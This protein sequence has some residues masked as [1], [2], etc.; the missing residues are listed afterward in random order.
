MTGMDLGELGEFGFLERV[1]SWVP[2]GST[3]VG[4][5]DDAAV[6]P[7]GELVSIVATT[8][9]L[10]EDVHFRWAWSS[11]SDVGFKAISANVSD[12]A[13][14]GAEARW[15]LVSLVAPKGTDTD[16][17]EGL[18]GGLVEGCERYGCELVGGD[19]TTGPSLT[20]AVTALGVL[21][22]DPLTRSGARPGDVLAV[23][24][25]LGLAAC[26]VALLSSGDPAGLGPEDADA[27]LAA[28]RRPLAR[29]GE[30]SAMR[31]AGAVRACL[32]LSDGLLSD[33]RRLAERSEV[34]VEVDLD[35]VPV[36]PEVRR[37]CEARGW[38]PERMGLAGG[39]DYELLVALP[40]DR[41]AEAGAPLTPVGRVVDE[42][43]WLVRKGSREPL[44]EGG[45][46]HFASG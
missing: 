29:T 8:D 4:I 11:G 32:D 33:V 38:D 10:V 42:G 6:V 34:G 26:G 12:V 2:P 1:R 41:L 20:L 44:P 31:R 18:Y 7:L 39:E 43:L 45:W 3:A 21:D 24:G 35:S 36:A 46:D 5:G 27:C 28:H 13:A 17:L 40:E 9:S 14:M 22:G 37:V 19:T 30:G 15:A 23:T 16:L 25:P